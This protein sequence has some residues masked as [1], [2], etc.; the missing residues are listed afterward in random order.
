MFCFELDEPPCSTFAF[1][2]F[3]EEESEDGAGRFSTAG[4]E[5]AR[6]LN[7]SRS[8]NKLGSIILSRE[9]GGKRQET[10]IRAS[11]TF[12]SGEVCS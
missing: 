10:G 4:V 11:K 3:E 9:A 12:K 2:F 5:R 6:F 1:F 7:S 8:L